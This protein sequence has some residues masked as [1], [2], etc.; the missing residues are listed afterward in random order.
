[1]LVNIFT[2]PLSHCIK[3]VNGVI[4]PKAIS[5]FG[6]GLN[7]KILK[8]LVRYASFCIAAF[9]LVVSKFIKKEDFYILL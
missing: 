8:K 3:E 1:M 9:Q 7:V 6:A 5:A 4:M 2:H